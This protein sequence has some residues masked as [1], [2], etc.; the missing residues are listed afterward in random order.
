MPV[1]RDPFLQAHRLRHRLYDLGR[2][3]PISIRDQLVRSELLVARLF[4]ARVL[5][6]GAQLFV[7]GAGVAGVNTALLA[8]RQGVKV[9]LVDRRP[10][11]FGWQRRCDTR[12]IDPVQYDWPATHSRSGRWG[13]GTR[14]LGFAAG[15]AHD[16]AREWEMEFNRHRLALGGALRFFPG[17][18]F[19][20][21]RL[22]HPGGRWRQEVAV[23][24]PR[25]VLAP[26]HYD[27]VGVGSPELDAREAGCR[28]RGRRIGHLGALVGEAHGEHRIDAVAPAAH[29][30][31]PDHVCGPGGCW[32]EQ[33][34]VHL[35]VD[36]GCLHPGT[37]GRTLPFDGVVVRHGVHPAGGFKGFMRQVPPAL[38]G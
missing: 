20:R 9:V 28:R 22:V 35:L 8:V 32:G 29:L 24:L 17:A 27:A 38:A 19:S 36:H 3:T 37:A 6:A 25:A 14:P 10:L 15:W 31:M 34:A 13:M 26:A 16:I 1:S 4:E 18:G 7:V 21:P 23:H 30:G 2:R 5:Y 12:W 33:H 11:P